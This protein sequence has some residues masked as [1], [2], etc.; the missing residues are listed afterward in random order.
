MT[1]ANQF[2]LLEI[3]HRHGNDFSLHR[4]EEGARRALYVYID[5]WWDEWVD[6]PSIPE[7]VDEAIKIYFDAAPGEDAYFHSV[8][9][10]D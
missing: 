7:D 1:E 9:L 10:E 5:Q 2:T 6:D 4:S 3:T 8:R